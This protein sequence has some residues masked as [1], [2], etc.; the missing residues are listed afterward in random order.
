[1]QL[2]DVHSHHITPYYRETMER[3]G[4]LD[5]DLTAVPSWEAE[6]L[7][8]HMED[9]GI[10]HSV[11]SATSP[12]QSFGDKGIALD[13]TRE[14]NEAGADCARRHEGRFSLAASLPLP[15]VEESIEEIKYA[16]ETLG[17]KAVRILTN[18]IGVY[19]GNPKTDPVFAELNRRKAVVILHPTRPPEFPKDSLSSISFSMLEF[20]TESCRAVINL[21]FSGTIRRYPDVRFVVP[22]CG[23]H[24]IPTLE[25]LE[26]HCK[27]YLSANKDL[28]QT[29]FLEDASTLY[30]DIAGD[31]FPRQLATLLTF[32]DPS[33]VLY[34]TDYPWRSSEMANRVL[35][36]FNEK[37]AGSPFADQ[38]FYQ[39]ALTLF[40]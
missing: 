25:R 8:E 9:V 19:P 34:G 37:Y 29:D 2:I 38:L 21:I 31:P 12:N 13:L 39:N 22:H 20:L 35:A 18:S 26:K 14:G 10:T 36:K 17:A 30:F 4:Q 11:L 40:S 27:R 24:L 32:T 23:A 1:M 28:T 7:L 15:Y 5:A 16:Y 3:A 6:G 33:H